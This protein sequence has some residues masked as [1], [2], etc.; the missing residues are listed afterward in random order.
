MSEKPKPVEPTREKSI[1]PVSQEAARRALAEI[2]RDPV[3]AMLIE[4]QHLQVANSFLNSTLIEY[5]VMLTGRSDSSFAEG[6]LWTHRIVRHQVAEVDQTIPLLS[7]LKIKEQQKARIAKLEEL[8]KTNVKLGEHY[9]SKM[10]EITKADS[11]F[12]DAIDE[13]SRY[14]RDKY[15]LYAGVVETYKSLKTGIESR[16]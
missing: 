4:A 1:F 5:G 13:M 9:A 11:V 16:K 10:G 15:L 6:V 12:G 7:S 8:K 14:R 2:A 3:Q